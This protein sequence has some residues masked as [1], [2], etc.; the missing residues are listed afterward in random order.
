LGCEVGGAV[1][2]F[3]GELRAADVVQEAAHAHDLEHALVEVARGLGQEHAEDRDRYRMVVEVLA[4]RD[5]LE[6]DGERLGLLDQEAH[7]VLHDL[8]RR[9][10]GLVADAHLGEEL[11]HVL[12]GHVEQ[13]GDLLVR[14]GVGVVEDL[15]GGEL[16]EGVVQGLVAGLD[17]QLLHALLDVLGQALVVEPGG[18]REDVG[19][20]IFRQFK[21]HV[22]GDVPGGRPERLDLDREV[23]REIGHLPAYRRGREGTRAG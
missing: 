21:V 12:L 9:A 7:V 11:G 4:V 1:G 16:D 22:E 20:I 2:D 17:V 10:G 18:A 15:V 5:Q 6:Q 14:R 19:E 8:L 3:L 23:L 13:G